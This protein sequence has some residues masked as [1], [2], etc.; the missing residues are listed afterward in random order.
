MEHV[1]ISNC[2]D[3]AIAFEANLLPFEK[4]KRILY[5]S[6]QTVFEAY[7]EIYHMQF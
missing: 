5:T 1:L 7:K 4:K 6:M 3:K 2:L